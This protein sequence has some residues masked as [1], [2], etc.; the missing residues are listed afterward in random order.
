MTIGYYGRD[1][2]GS[3]PYGSVPPPIGVESASA[4]N[5]THVQVN[6]TQPVDFT[7]TPILTPGNYSISP[8]LTVLTV[9][10]AGLSA[11]TLTTTP[12]TNI[13]YTVTVAAARSTFD[14]LL[15]PLQNSAT[16]TGFPLVPGFFAVATAATRV[17]AIFS[18]VMRNDA[19]LSNASNYS[20]ADFNGF[21]L[22]VIAATP[23]QSINPISVVLTLGTPLGE[24]DLYV[25]T[26]SSSVRTA[27]GLMVVPPTSTFQWIASDNQCTVPLSLFTGEVADSFFGNPAGLIYFSPALNV[28]TPNSFI[29]VEDVDVCTTAYDS[30]SPPVMIDPPVLFTYGGGIVPTPNPDPYLLNQ[31]V[32][33]APFPRNF[34]AQI[35]LGFTGAAN[36][37]FY[38]PPVDTSCS[39]IIAQQFALGYVAL[40]N[41]PAFY[42]LTTSTTALSGTF[43]VIN[44]SPSVTASTSQSGALV[45]GDLLIFGEQPGV[46]YTVLSVAG[47]AITLTNNYLGTTDVTSTATKQ[48]LISPQPTP[49]MFI[50]AKNKNPIPPGPE[51][52]LVLHVQLSGEA[53]MPGPIVHGVVPPM[54]AKK[55]GHLAA[56]M[57]GAS[58]FVAAA[59][60]PP[61]ILA[62]AS[63]TAGSNM[64]AVGKE[65]RAALASI[66]GISVV[67]ALA[68]EGGPPPTVI[69]GSSFL[70]AGATVRRSVAAAITGGSSFLSTGHVRRGAVAAVQGGATVYADARARW[71]AHAHI[72]ASSSVSADATVIHKAEAF[73]VGIANATATAS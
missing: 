8:T 23:E 36:Q 40:L 31:C 7:F 69:F 58:Q 70:A 41:D 62:Q 28:D 65:K 2:Y 20:I 4:I 46:E 56:S 11:V 15:N 73:P 3:S 72:T 50:T 49:P 37:D 66:A 57:A 17:R 71:K 22:T 24:T 29:Q 33:W 51:S 14:V 19:N 25:C 68:T 12:Q 5:G 30:Y 16:F 67:R 48:T 52:I 13:L 21:P 38:T 45:Y 63:L 32:L 27:A 34:E 6:F 64:V 60:P 61:V 43:H 42:M 47:T 59:G 1:P 55:H 39:V 54:V 53:N 10:Q 44:G 9:E 18:T 26:V 35:T